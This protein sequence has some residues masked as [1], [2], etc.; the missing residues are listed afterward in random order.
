MLL[1]MKSPSAGQWTSPFATLVCLGGPLDAAFATAF[2]AGCRV[3]LP[4]WKG[5]L[6][7]G[8]EACA[9]TSLALH[10][11]IFRHRFKNL[12]PKNSFVRV[13]SSLKAYSPKLPNDTPFKL[14]QNVWHKPKFVRTSPP[15]QWERTFT[16]RAADPN[17]LTRALIG[18]IMG[19]AE[20]PPH[21]ALGHS[22]PRVLSD[23][24]FP[25][26]GSLGSSIGTTFRVGGCGPD[27][28]DG[29]VVVHVA[30]IH[31]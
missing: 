25:A 17:G 20:C 18:G 2:L 28:V 4:V 19:D 26:A 1:M 16:A 31:M 9:T 7:H 11:V 10:L 12:F 8:R 30:K 29:G 13:G 6:L 15:D 23:S 3:N 22:E 14:F 24:G 27:L 21:Q 5:R